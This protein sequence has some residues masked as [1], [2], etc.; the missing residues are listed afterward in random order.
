M[1]KEEYLGSCPSL[2][3]LGVHMSRRDLLCM[4]F[5]RLLEEIAKSNKQGTHFRLVSSFKSSYLD[6]QDFVYI[7]N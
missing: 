4:M 5:A 1:E 7:N 6:A 3:L 2:K